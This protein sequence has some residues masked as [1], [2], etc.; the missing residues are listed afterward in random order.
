MK[1]TLTAA[2][3]LVLGL[4]AT[5]QDKAELRYTF[6]KG[7]KFTYKLSYG[8]S[9]HI[10]KVPEVLQGI[11]SEDPIDVKFEG[12]IEAEVAELAENGTALLNGTWKTAK[13]KGHLFVNDID[14]N[15]DAATAKKVEDKPKKAED[16]PLPGLGD[17]Q[18]QLAALVRA[19]LKL[20]VDRLGRIAVAD[21]G[22]KLGELDAAMQSMN[23]LM[24]P[25]P[26][27]KVGKGDTWKDEIKVGI[28][29]VGGKVDI[30]IRTTNTLEGTEK[31]GDD[32][33]LVVKS[34]FAI[35]TLPG[36]KEEPLPADIQAKVKTEGDGEGKMYFST[37]QNRSLKSQSGLKIKVV[38]TFPNPGGGNDEL[39]IKA[40]LK[41]ASAHELGK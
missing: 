40:L 12:L 25:L 37:A 23:G 21:G 38:A 35:G 5:A 41:I 27:D 6:K 31:V 33:C 3:I 7:E 19:P 8:M 9:L 1:Q 4:G 2:L 18:D 10:D 17:I 16:D 26:K 30:K 14:F 15:Y 28:P 29:G 22:G 32:D 34:K 13:A 36:E 11:I 20:N 24:G 39:E